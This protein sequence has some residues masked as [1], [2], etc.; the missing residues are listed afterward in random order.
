[1]VVLGGKV[2]LPVF[3]DEKVNEN[4][5]SEGINEEGHHR[6][7]LLGERN[8][9]AIHSKNQVLLKSHSHR[10]QPERP[11]HIPKFQIRSVN[12]HRNDTG[13]L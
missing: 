9:G 4:E 10:V 5:E 6:T 12:I 1:M 2:T 13:R 8:E 11:F 3:Y 7:G